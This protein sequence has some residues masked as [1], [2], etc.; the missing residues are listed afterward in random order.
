MEEHEEATEV[1][2]EDQHSEP[3]TDGSEL[4]S[5]DEASEESFPASDPPANTPIT[6]IG[7]PCHGQG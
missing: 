4:D 7:I 2:I 3:P 6:R 1:A 5:I